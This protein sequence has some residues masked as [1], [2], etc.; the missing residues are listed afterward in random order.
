MGRAAQ[1][2]DAL[3]ENAKAY[4]HVFDEACSTCVRLYLTNGVG[5][6]PKV[7]LINEL[8]S[9]GSNIGRKKDDMKPVLGATHPW[10]R[11]ELEGMPLG[12][13]HEWDADKKQF[14]IKLT[15]RQELLRSK[16]KITISYD[17]E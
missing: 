1:I 2:K 13:N 10:C 5:S 3:G 8:M 14:Q 6:Q 16:I 15:P 7:F 12:D 4:K 11:C 17:D 9:N